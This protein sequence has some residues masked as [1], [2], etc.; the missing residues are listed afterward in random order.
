MNA[1]KG[2]LLAIAV[3]LVIG[4]SFIAN[5]IA[6][7][8]GVAPETGAFFTFLFAS[9]FSM[10]TILFKKKASY[11][12]KTFVKHSNPM[13][14]MGIINAVAAITWFYSLEL[15]GPS[16][17]GFILRFSTIIMVFLS[18][19]FL[20]E[21]F[22]KLEALGGAITVV[23]AILISYSNGITLQTGILIALFSAAAFSLAQ[24]ISKKY[25]EKI[26]PVEMNTIRNFIM[27]FVIALFAAATGKIIMP[28][29]ETMPFIMLAAFAGPF[30]SFYLR[31][32]AMQSMELSKV[33][34]ITSLE[35]LVILVYSFVVF[36]EVLHG[37][38]L[39]GSGLI[40]VGI[41]VLAS[42]RH[43][44]KLLARWFL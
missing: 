43:A 26:P 38:Q 22:N 33:A 27:L 34:I 12:K 31:Y 10:T 15:L 5:T 28:P 2:Y 18:V 13:L 41:M 30:L 25:I 4:I 8:G 23:G 39:I 9:V 11:L 42:A 24:F 14:I 40:F 21:S 1:A 32:K 44:P 6:Q 20:K 29:L 37:I 3:S 36:G 17:L 16:L 7:R 19:V 35:P